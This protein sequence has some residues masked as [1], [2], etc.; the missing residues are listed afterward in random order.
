MKTSY[1]LVFAGII[2]VLISLVWYDFLLKGAYVSG[3]YKDPYNSFVDLKFKDFDTVDLVSSTAVNVKFVQ[4]PF[5]VR[6][7]SNFSPYTRIKQIGKKLR[8]NAVFEDG[9]LSD[10][11]TYTLVISCPHLSTINTDAT[12][13]ANGKHVTDTVVRDD[14][15]MRQVLI[16][17]FKQDSLTINQDY[18]CTVILANDHFQTVNANIGKKEKSGS[19]L[20]ILENNQI[21][22]A[23]LAILNTSKLILNNAQIGDMNYHLA[24]SAKLI[25][26]GK[27]QNL[28]KKSKSE[29]K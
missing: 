17:G 22:K 6:I 23:N 18:G 2:L 21:Q 11:S 4:G 27:A 10:P 3:K 9:Y 13:K 15:R 5:K 28:L 14:W 25:L 20:V 29:Q 26:T 8:I 12:Y 19:N 16:E 1:K 24:D 7:D